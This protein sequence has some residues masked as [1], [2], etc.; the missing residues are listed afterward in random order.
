MVGLLGCCCSCCSEKTSTWSESFATTP[1]ANGNPFDVVRNIT[2]PGCRSYPMSSSSTSTTQ[3]AQLYI[4]ADGSTPLY[5]G[6]NGP[7][8]SPFVRMKAFWTDDTTSYS[9]TPK[10]QGWSMVN[11]S[12]STMANEMSLTIDSRLIAV[13]G[14]TEIELGIKASYRKQVNRNATTGNPVYQYRIDLEAYKTI[15]GGSPVSEGTRTTGWGNFA[16]HIIPGFQWQF[17]LSLYQ[18]DCTS[19]TQSRGYYIQ[20]YLQ[21]SD[22]LDPGFCT[23]ADNRVLSYNGQP[24][25]CYLGWRTDVIWAIA[26]RTSGTGSYNFGSHYIRWFSANWGS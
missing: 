2:G 9:Q 1:V 21:C 24:M 20:P 26:S 5:L 17:I 22:T 7:R 19:V 14:G 23:L 25:D 11:P 15:G 6:F 13:F 18:T 8:S 4:N 10:M 3:T 12:S 16:Y